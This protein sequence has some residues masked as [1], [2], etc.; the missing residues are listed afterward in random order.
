MNE[1][2]VS[3][4]VAWK[5]HPDITEGCSS[6]ECY[7]NEGLLWIPIYLQCICLPGPKKINLI[8]ATELFNIPCTEIVKNKICFTFM[9]P[10][11]PCKRGACL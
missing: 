5:E 8:I 2:F 11:H 6:Y 1:D 9:N 10:S 7:L 3:H 4:D